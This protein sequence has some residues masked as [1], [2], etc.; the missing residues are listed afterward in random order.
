MVVEEEEVEEIKEVNMEGR[1]GR[2]SSMKTGKWKRNKWR[3]VK[4]DGRKRREGAAESQG[5]QLSQ[6]TRR[7][8]AIELENVWVNV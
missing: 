7:K 4:G 3:K 5:G 2:K 8:N 1:G 6:R